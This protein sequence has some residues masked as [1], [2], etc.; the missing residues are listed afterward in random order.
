MS[1]GKDKCHFKKGYLGGV[2][3]LAIIGA[4]SMYTFSNVRRRIINSHSSVDRLTTTTTAL[5]DNDVLVRKVPDF[6]IIGVRKGGTKALISI[7][8]SHPQILPAKGEVHFFDNLDIYTDKG[9]SW[10]VS[11][12]PLSKKGELVVEKT[13]SYFVNADVP[14]RMFESLPQSLKLILIVR[15]PITRSISDFTQLDTK[16][17]RFSKTRPSLEKVVFKSNG[18]IINTTSVIR[19]S[20]Y[21]VHYRRW[22]HYFNR[23][24]I[25]IVDGD[26]LASS[27]LKELVKVEEY[28]NIDSYFTPEKLYFNNTKGFYCWKTERNS[29]KCLGSAKGR[30]H[31]EISE[32]TKL[33]L[34][35]YF[36][37]H[38]FRFCE[39]AHL[40]ISLCSVSYPYEQTSILFASS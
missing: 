11:R 9:M 21:D 5:D 3:V 26:Q 29:S 39:M 17:M 32:D 28:L 33:K 10:Y 23:N 7:L 34:H 6:I 36:K 15:D 8:G 22:L 37:P 18:D 1:T 24:R 25:L 19:D 20:L 40:N 31:P 30:K 27:P 16:R 4:I 35:T 12:M 13:P 14:K 2:V 38:M